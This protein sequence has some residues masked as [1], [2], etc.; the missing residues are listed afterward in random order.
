M[1]SM[2]GFVTAISVGM[3]DRPLSQGQQRN[4]SKRDHGIV[5][6]DGA[7]CANLVRD[8]SQ[9][10]RDKSNTGAGCDLRLASPAT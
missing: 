7:I 5:L 9:L 6:L 3:L 1:C 4:G 10:L 2:G 8:N